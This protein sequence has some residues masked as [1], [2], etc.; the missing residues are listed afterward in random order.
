MNAREKI[1]WILADIE[2]DPTIEGCVSFRMLGIR[3][4]LAAHDLVPI[5][6]AYDPLANVLL[7]QTQDQH[8]SRL[9]AENDRLRAELAALNEHVDELRAKLMRADAPPLTETDIMFEVRKA[10]PMGGVRSHTA[11]TEFARGIIDRRIKE[12]RG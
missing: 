8:V 10:F 3:A 1:E 12:A 5:M 11:I 7:R 9:E 2:A 4:I 6:E